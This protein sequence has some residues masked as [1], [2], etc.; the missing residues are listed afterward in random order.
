M[1]QARVKCKLCPK[2]CELSPNERGDCRA[3]VNLDGKLITLVY[4]KPCSVHVDPMEKKPMF[5]F[6]PGTPIFSIATAGCNLHCKFCQNWEISQKNPEETSNLDLP[7]DAVVAAAK[8]NECRSI[9]YTYS[10][11]MI[12]FEYARDTAAVA[13]AAGLK[14]VLVTA[15]YINEKPLRELCKVTDGANLDIKGFTE[16]FYREICAGD[17]ATVLRTFEVMMEEGVFVELTTL[18]V[19]TINDDMGKIRELCKWIVARA[20]P[21]VP[22]HFS[23]F[24]PMYVMRD[25]YPTPAKTLERAREVALDAGEKHVYIGNVPG[26]NED[27]ACPGCGKV[28]IARYG[29]TVRENL[30]KD[31]K[32]PFC[33]KLIRGVWR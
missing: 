7:P 8:R 23:R 2:E 4:G 25:I 27:T 3:R 18:I 26:E 19:P 33:G 29:F 12:Y 24:Y 11:P 16:D 32:C 28:V 21:E 13:R 20:G 31:G 30:L 5:H 14:N 15:G 9:A 17:L 1:S 6:L 22:H 10:E